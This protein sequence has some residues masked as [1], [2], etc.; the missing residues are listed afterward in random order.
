MKHA[1][2]ES[3]KT[4]GERHNSSMQPETRKTLGRGT[5][6]VGRQTQRQRFREV[7]VHRGAGEAREC[8]R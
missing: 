7:E 4:L 1:A 5:T 8:V 2:R 3:R 6:A